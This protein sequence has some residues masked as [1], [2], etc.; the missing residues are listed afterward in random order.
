MSQRAA[1]ATEEQSEPS[2]VMERG[3]WQLTSRED[4]QGGQALDA[5]ADDRREARTERGWAAGRVC[6]VRGAHRDDGGGGAVPWPGV[7]RVLVPPV[8]CVLLSLLNVLCGGQSMNELPRWLFRNVVVMVVVGFNARYVEE[9]LTRRGNTQRPGTQKQGG[10]VGLFGREETGKRASLLFTF[11][12]THLLEGGMPTNTIVKTCELFKDGVPG[13]LAS[14][15]T[16]TIHTLTFQGT[17]KAF[18]G[19]IVVPFSHVPHADHDLTFHRFALRPMT[20][21]GTTLIR[22]HDHLG[23][24]ITTHQGHL[25]R[26]ADERLVGVFSHGPANHQPRQEVE[27]DCDGE[28]SFAGPDKGCVTDPRGSGGQ[29]REL[30]IE[31]IGSRSD[32]RSSFRSQGF[33]PFGCGTQLHLLHQ[34]SRAFSRAANAPAAHLGVN[35]RTAIHASKG[36]KDPM[37]VSC[38]FAVFSLVCAGFTLSPVGRAAHTD[39]EHPTQRADWIAFRMLFKKGRHQTW[40]REKMASAFL[41]MPRF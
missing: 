29:S 37:D 13:L 18:H 32:S 27:N 39:G 28:P 22:V 30:S 40:L 14:S 19:R 2:A 31:P 4:A 35:P 23:R 3:I 33:A 10:L 12:R 41:K 36:L 15:E 17:E 5:G 6:C 24:G 25:Q 7:Q 34:T 1:K 21:V 11:H 8:P 26:L 38:S 20:G 16:R 9:G